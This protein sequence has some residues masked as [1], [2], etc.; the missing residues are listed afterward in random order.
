MNQLLLDAG[1]ATPGDKEVAMEW[2][3]E[4]VTASRMPGMANE[5]EFASLRA[6]EGLAADDQFTRLMIRHHAGGIAMAKY[7]AANGKNDRVKRLAAAIANVQ[8]TE[9]VEMEL[10]PKALGLAPIDIRHW[11][12]ARFALE[13]ADHCWRYTQR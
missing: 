8:R 12:R 9:I 6:A 13:V 11:R 10:R 5:G 2:M 4:P 3:G 1:G 7:A